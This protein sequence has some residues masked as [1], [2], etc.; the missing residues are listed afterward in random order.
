MGRGRMIDNKEKHYLKS[1]KSDWNCG[2]YF[3]GPQYSMCKKCRDK[4]MC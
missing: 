1:C 4:E 3:Y 2:E